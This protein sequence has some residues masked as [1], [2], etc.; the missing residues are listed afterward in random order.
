MMLTC[1]VISLL[2]LAR[3][4][5]QAQLSSSRLLRFEHDR[6]HGHL[7]WNVQLEQELVAIFIHI[8]D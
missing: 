5:S 4:G 2:D 7:E 1:A 3:Y 8:G 6:T